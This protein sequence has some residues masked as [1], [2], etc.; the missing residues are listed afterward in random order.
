MCSPAMCQSCGKTTYRGCGQ[1]VEQIKARVGTAN[2]CTCEKAAPSS[3]LS[4]LTSIFR[5]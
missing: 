4:F 3:P 5:R 1:H 2:W